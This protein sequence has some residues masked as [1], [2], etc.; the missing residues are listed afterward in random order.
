[1]TAAIVNHTLPAATMSTCASIWVVSVALIA[2]VVGWSLSV[3][4]IPDASVVELRPL[5]QVPKNNALAPGQHLYTVRASLCSHSRPCVCSG[6]VMYMHVRVIAL[7]TS[8]WWAGLPSWRRIVGA[9]SGVWSRCHWASGRTHR[10][11]RA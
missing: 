5:P 9:G 11:P 7:L 3:T 6:V 1:M 8:S 2:A 4:P 10:S